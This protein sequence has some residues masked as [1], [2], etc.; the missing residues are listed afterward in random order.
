MCACEAA[1]KLLLSVRLLSKT[2]RYKREKWVNLATKR[3]EGPSPPRWRC[4]THL[5]VERALLFQLSFL[6]FLVNK[7]AWPWRGQ[8]VSQQQ[9]VVLLEMG[10]ETLALL[11]F[12]FGLYRLGGELGGF[13][14]EAT[15]VVINAGTSPAGDVASGRRRGGT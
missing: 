11:L 12:H 4:D 13:W 9:D 3:L 6:P 2:P 7:R 15:S 10:R 1:F 14:W 8:R 5:A